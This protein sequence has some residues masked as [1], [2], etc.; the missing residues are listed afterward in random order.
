M[1]ALTAHLGELGRPEVVPKRIVGGIG[2]AGVK[3]HLLELPAFAGAD[4]QG[5]LFHVEVW[6]GIPKSLFRAVEEV[7]TVNEDYGSFDG[8]FGRHQGKNN[9][10]R[11]LAACRAGG[12]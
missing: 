10:A 3:T 11:G 6:E 4:L 7:L 1:N 12:R 2:K 9:P 8:G 5:E